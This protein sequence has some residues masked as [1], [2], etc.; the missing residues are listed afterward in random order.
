VKETTM[1]NDKKSKHPSADAETLDG[2]PPGA[3]APGS[4]GTGAPNL[5]DTPDADNAN[6]P[7]PEGQVDDPTI[8]PKEQ[9]QHAAEVADPTHGADRP[10]AAGRVRVKLNQNIT[11]DGQHKMAGETVDMDEAEADAHGDRVEPV[12]TSA[13]RGAKK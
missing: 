13:R 9:A 11:V 1:A 3:H 8:S 12:K 4:F 2:L 7:P 5:T 6:A 10:L